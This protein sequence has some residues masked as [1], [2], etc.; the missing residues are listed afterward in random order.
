MVMLLGACTG[1]FL[2]TRFVYFLGFLPYRFCGGL[3]L[4][5]HSLGKLFLLFSFGL[6]G[7]L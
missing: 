6:D 3:G 5:L 2:A 1:D 4:F 7:R